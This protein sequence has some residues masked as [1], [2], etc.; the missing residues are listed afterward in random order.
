MKNIAIEQTILENVKYSTCVGHS[1][2]K[3]KSI[4][5]WHQVILFSRETVPLKCKENYKLDKSISSLIHK[6]NH[7]NIVTLYLFK[8]FQYLCTS[9]SAKSNE[10]ILKLHDYLWGWQVYHWINQLSQK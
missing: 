2:M 7:K 10:L 6:L 9:I 1:L 8:A 3:V 4:L 5:L